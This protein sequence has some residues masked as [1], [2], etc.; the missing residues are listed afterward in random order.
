MTLGI[1]EIMVGDWLYITDHPM[2]K[3]QN[4]LSL[5]TF[6]EVWLYLNQSLLQQK[7]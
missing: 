1:D 2:K 5:N 3:K 7:Y 4:R 6:F